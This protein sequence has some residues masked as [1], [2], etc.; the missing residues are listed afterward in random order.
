MNILKLIKNRQST[1]IYKNKQVPFKIVQKIIMA[2]VWGPSLLAV[3]FQPWEF[4]VVRNREVIKKI[5]DILL[6]KSMAIGIGGSA[7]L[8]ISANTVFN[9]PTLII[10]HNSSC[11]SNFVKRF[12]KIF[13]K[14]AKSAEISAISAAVQNMLLVAESVKVGTCWLDTPLFC[15]EEINALLKNK[16][17]LCAILT[18]GYPGQKGYR[19]RR[20]KFSEVVRYI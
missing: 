12:N 9:S 16:N 20:R 14:I 13:E 2:G 11:V 1:R 18:I 8:R 10:V 4:T 3:G 17:K 15:E 6:K 19:S 5:G 7:I